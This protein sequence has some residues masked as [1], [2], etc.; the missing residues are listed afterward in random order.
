MNHGEDLFG[1]G[2]RLES[3]RVRGILLRP[4]SAVRLRP[5]GRADIFDLAL[6]G[7]TATVESLEMDVEGTLYVAVVV[8]DDP[9]RD[10]GR[11]RQ[12]SHRFFFRAE[13]VEPLS[14]S[15][16]ETP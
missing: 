9:G 15:G 3:A 14:A 16:G 1:A 13:E 6:E 8:D 10:L 5:Q 7:K 11:L 4:G 2:E 12:T